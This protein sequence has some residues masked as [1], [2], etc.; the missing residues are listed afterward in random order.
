MKVV[1][2]A[3]THNHIPVV[4][5]G[6]MVIHC[7][8][9]TGYGLIPEVSKFANWFGALPHR[10]RVVIA[11]N[12]DFLFQEQPSL[13]RRMM[14][15][16]GIIYLEDEFRE[17]E[18]IKLY[19]TPHTPIFFDWA[20]NADEERQAELFAQIPE[21]LDILITH[22]PPR[23][24]LDEVRHDFKIRNIGSAQLLTAVQRAK[25]RYHCFGHAHS[26]HGSMTV[27]E[28]RFINVSN[29]NERYQLVNPPRIIEL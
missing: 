15:D 27:G 20:F 25:P 18:G 13:A 7:G 28:T 22:G 16:A 12:H 10:Y 1:L 2:L 29:C 9:M 5:D 23:G 14:R 24:I 3:D 19:G 21:G 8:D 17:L 6:D 4:P 26:N 11:G